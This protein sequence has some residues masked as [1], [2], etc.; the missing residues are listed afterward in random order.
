VLLS[1]TLTT[2]DVSQVVSVPISD[3]GS[4]YTTSNV[5]FNCIFD[6]EYVK[7]LL[8]SVNGFIEVRNVANN[9]VKFWLNKIDSPPN[10]N[11]FKI[12]L[13]L[14][15]FFL[16]NIIIPCSAWHDLVRLKWIERIQLFVQAQNI[17]KIHNL[18]TSSSL[19][20]CKLKYSMKQLAKSRNQK[21]FVLNFMILDWSGPTETFDLGASLGFV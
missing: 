7:L 12:N 2:A 8:F 5:Q 15:L 1:P 13:L 4:P 21:R 14:L 9:H 3:V 18:K 16:S 10:N 11:N 19:D 17:S 20:L 6:G